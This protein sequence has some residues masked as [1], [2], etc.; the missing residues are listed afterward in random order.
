[1]KN[2]RIWRTLSLLLL[3]V[4][5]LCTVVAC[6]DKTPEGP[7]GGEEN[8]PVQQWPDDGELR[9][10]D[11]IAD[12]TVMR[13]ESASPTLRT[14]V[15]VVYSTMSTR[16]TGIKIGTDYT[17]DPTPIVNNSY[18]LLIG[19]TNRKESLDA[20]DE[21]TAKHGESAWYHIGIR[22]N[23]IVVVG[24][25]D[26]NTLIALR[27][28]AA[29][30]LAVGNT[31]LEV[32]V[33]MSR[34]YESN[35]LT[36]ISPASKDAFVASADV[37]AEPYFADR[38]GVRDVTDILQS[39]IDSVSALGGGV[40]YVPYGTYRLSKTLTVPSYVT[41]R[42]DYVDPNGHDYSRATLFLLDAKGSFKTSSAVLVQ[43]SAA[44]QG[45]TFYYEKQS[46]TSPIEY[47]PTIETKGDVCTV[48]DC[49]FIN[50]YYGIFSGETA[51]GMLTVDN[52]RG[53]TLWRG[54]DNNNSADICVTTNVYFS[55]QYWAGAGEKF[56]APAE[57]DIRA[58]MKKNG[59]IGMT[60]GD[61]DRDTYEGITLDGFAT[62]IYNRQPTRAGLCGSYT[63]VYIL[64]A[65][66]GLDLHGINGAYGLLMTNC[67]I[68][69]SEIAVR[70]EVTTA[71]ETP[72]VYLLNC[73]VKGT[74]SDHVIELSSGS[75][76]M[77]TSYSMKY[78]RPRVLATKLFNLADYGA[79][80]TGKSDVSAALQKALDDAAAA[81]GGI[82]YM[83]AG[84][85]RLT[86]PVTVGE[87]TVIMGAQQNPQ[88]GND[89]FKGTVMLVTYGEGGKESD[90]AAITV[91]GSNSGVTGMTVY[92][93]N[94]G[95]S[96]KN[97][98]TDSP[99]EYSYFVRCK[100]KDTFATNLCLVA[101]SRGVCFD[102]A[103]GFI[104]DRILMT[105]FDNGIG[106]FNAKNGV[107]TRIHTN[108]TYHNIGGKS[109][110]V[111][112][113]DWMTDYTRVYELIDTH[114]SPRM[115]LIKVSGSRDIEVRHAF[116]YGANTFLWAADSDI[117]LVN[118][119]SGHIGHGK[120][121]VFAGDVELWGV[122]FIRENPHEAIEI[123]K[124]GYMMT[125]YQFKAAHQPSVIYLK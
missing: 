22:G 1:M 39:A 82:V 54:L 108:G 21:M 64:D 26:N 78:N 87:K 45:L 96:E 113:P 38:T 40:V 58:L 34:T 33:N 95:V 74:T 44:V 120:S 117:V 47:K 75:V 9:K 84:L 90:T 61:C 76:D 83:P 18:E 102:G 86:S 73:A 43:S 50:S 36:V 25:D 16:F 15:S 100:G 20:I 118:C 99:V 71:K 12:Y 27:Y 109:H 63:Y 41:L 11:N 14:E 68:E 42:G 30:Y 35:K 31:E 37:S 28:F 97:T 60:L 77:D 55:P 52:V 101:A 93:P 92:Y 2:R 69:A 125:L 114:L 119:E 115:T 79:D 85:Y 124:A 57:S 121:F 107:I 4:L 88:K 81:G 123:E 91:T 112:H 46:V 8:G 29:R 10:I 53:T 70:N 72:N 104:A 32:P 6:R 23:K 3:A 51:K 105:V 48:K 59:S 89:S 94:N 5:C 103:D 111:L 80:A 7:V 106:V 56:G 67:T 66:I 49:N 19:K 65:K 116:H 24:S 17:K 98:L 110:T 122:N 62:G 13:S